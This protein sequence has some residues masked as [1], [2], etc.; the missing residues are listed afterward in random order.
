MKWTTDL[1][2]AFLGQQADV[3]DAAQRM[4]AKA[5]GAGSLKSTKQQKVETKVVE[6]K[7]VVVIEAVAKALTEGYGAAKKP[8]HGTISRF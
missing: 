6:S 7:T 5:Q 3:M 1:G 2:N 8:F 4:R